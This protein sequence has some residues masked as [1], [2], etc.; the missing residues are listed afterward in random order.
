[1]AVHVRGRIAWIG[2]VDLDAQRRKFLGDGYRDGIQGRLGRVVAEQIDGMEL[3]S[4][5][6][7]QADGAQPALLT[8]T[9]SRSVSRPPAHAAADMR[10][11]MMDSGTCRATGRT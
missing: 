3:A 11:P 7:R 8:S 6:E 2:R 5:I 4:W 10:T 9:S 1:V